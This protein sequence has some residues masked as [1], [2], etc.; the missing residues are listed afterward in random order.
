MSA[1]DYISLPINCIILDYANPRFKT[2][3]QFDQNTPQ[4]TLAQATIKQDPNA[5][6]ELLKDIK[7]RKSLL[8]AQPLC[9]LPMPSNS[10]QYLAL[11]GNRRITS[12]KLISSLL[13]KDI[14]C[15]N[16][17]LITF[18][19]NFLNKLETFLNNITTQEITNIKSL[20][21]DCYLFK[22]REEA[23]P[24]LLARH[25]GQSG[26]AGQQ[27][28]KPIDNQLYQGD[29]TL[30]DVISFVERN[31]T[32][33]DN[34]WL[35]IKD[36]LWEQG[37][38]TLEYII[39][40]KFFRD[41]FQISSKQID[42]TTHPTF[43]KNPEILI[44]ML[45]AIVKDIKN[46][47]INTRLINTAAKQEVYIKSLLSNNQI[48]NNQNSSSLKSPELFY[49]YTLQN[50]T[51][52]PRINQKPILHSR[53]QDSKINTL[54]PSPTVSNISIQK[55]VPTPLTSTPTQKVAI[56]TPKSPNQIK[57]LH[58]N[59]DIEKQLKRLKNEKLIHLYFSLTKT[60]INTNNHDYTPLLTVGLWAFL[61]TLTACQKRK[62]TTSFPDF[63]SKDKLTKFGFEKEKSKEYVE[64]FQTIS[65]HGNATKHSANNAY[66]NTAQ[67]NND[68]TCIEP[69]IIKCIEEAIQKKSTGQ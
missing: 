45:S 25:G 12:L 18:D 6:L 39:G 36:Y 68:L 2:R 22:T 5:F 52:H 64:K 40:N 4:K 20:Q 57:K 32:F 49:N 48:S 37:A 41:T 65:K 7:D 3:Y 29:A 23:E 69:V 10:Q 8:Q 60:K 55:T 13:N 66:Y 27:T 46:A 42:S 61:E 33:P 63:L 47:K 26:G 24:T 14:I 58:F 19:T 56:S 67:L 30:I 51:E 35:K 50:T 31:S 62:E 21:I 17:A 28:W 44:N 53:P 38:S 43:Q 16:N 9:V 1:T 34:E 11:D 59:S 15:K 54:T